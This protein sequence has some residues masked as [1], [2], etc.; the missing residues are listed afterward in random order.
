MQ[1]QRV[2]REEVQ[3]YVINHLE[4]YIRNVVQDMK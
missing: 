1:T 3:P 4:M 2:E